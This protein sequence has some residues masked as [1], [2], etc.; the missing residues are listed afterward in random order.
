[1]RHMTRIYSWDGGTLTSRDEF[2][3]SLEQAHEYLK[4]FLNGSSHAKIYNQQNQ[5]V[6]D[7]RGDATNT[8]A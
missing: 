6:H 4:H 5:I 7:S 8:Y 3:A 2:H 1:M